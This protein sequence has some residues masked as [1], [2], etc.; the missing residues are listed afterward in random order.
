M[1]EELQPVMRGKV[2][3][4]PKDEYDSLWRAQIENKIHQIIRALNDIDRQNKLGMCIPRKCS[5]C[6]HL[7]SSGD[8]YVMTSVGCY[9]LRCETK[10]LKEKKDGKAKS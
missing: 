1:I 6:G 5:G 8:P 9:C 7:M 3:V 4:I 10:R 2:V